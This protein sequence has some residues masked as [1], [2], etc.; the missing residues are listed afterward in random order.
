MSADNSK[1]KEHKSKNI[2]IKLSTENVSFSVG[3][4]FA[5]HSHCVQIR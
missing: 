1:I 3:F 5:V 4:L 2:L